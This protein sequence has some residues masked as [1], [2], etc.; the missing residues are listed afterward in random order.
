MHGMLNGNPEGPA[1]FRDQLFGYKEP[2]IKGKKEEKIGL[3]HKLGNQLLFT[4]P[5]TLPNEYL[6]YPAR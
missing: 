1:C 5:G 3:S 4:G 2:K 6:L